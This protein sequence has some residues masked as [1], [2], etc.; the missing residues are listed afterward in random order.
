MQYEP[1]NQAYRL[2]AVS[3]LIQANRRAHTEGQEEQRHEH[4]PDQDGT[5]KQNAPRCV[6]L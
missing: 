2:G 3:V 4:N 5:P 6:G 1:R